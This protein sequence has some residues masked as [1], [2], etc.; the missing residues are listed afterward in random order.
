MRHD[1]AYWHDIFGKCPKSVRQFRIRVTHTHI[2][3][4]TPQVVC[5]TINRSRCH[6]LK[7]CLLCLYSPGGLA[8][9]RTCRQ[10]MCIL[11]DIPTW[12][13][14]MLYSIWWWMI[15]WDQVSCVFAYK[16]DLILVVFRLSP[17]SECS[18]CSFGNF[19]G[20]RSI[21]TDVSE[22]NVGSIV[23]GDQDLILVRISVAFICDCRE[24]DLI[25]L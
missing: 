22:L 2:H 16:T 23:L 1:C 6:V 17:C 25:N 4:M 24:T 12:L 3:I 19:P 13:R 14:F 11:Q 21:K 15:H 9:Q 18:L 20:V 5:V 10:E 8:L 7:I